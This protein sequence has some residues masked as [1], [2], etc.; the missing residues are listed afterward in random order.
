MPCEIGPAVLHAF[1]HVPAVVVTGMRQ[2]G[3][4]TLLPEE[5]GSG[6]AAP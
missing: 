4:T 3:K 5:G 2:P 6:A 1:E